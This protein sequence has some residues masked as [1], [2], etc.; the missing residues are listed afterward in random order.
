ML[1]VVGGGGQVKV[2]AL[3]D[4]DPRDEYRYLLSIGTGHR[5]G[6]ST[7]SQVTAF[8]TVCIFW[9][10]TLSLRN[11]AGPGNDCEEL[12]VIAGGFFYNTWLLFFDKQADRGGEMDGL[13]LVNDDLQ[14]I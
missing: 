12:R 10:K 8:H 4:N 7:S 14:Q 1:S 3:Q 11:S 9:N 6:A 5:R 2:T 13:Y